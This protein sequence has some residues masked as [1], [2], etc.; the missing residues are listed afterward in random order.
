M[1]KHNII[2]RDITRDQFHSLVKR[3]AQPLEVNESDLE[4]LETSGVPQD[5]GCNGTDIHPDM[6]EGISD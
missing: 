1:S 6:I 5:D 3:A 4:R 2:K